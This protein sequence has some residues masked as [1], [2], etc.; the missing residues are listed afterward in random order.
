MSLTTFHLSEIL[1]DS[2]AKSS[3]N[4]DRRDSIV[5]HFAQSPRGFLL[6]LP[7]AAP[8]THPRIRPNVART[9]LAL[10]VAWSFLLP[11]FV[12]E[13]I[14][15]PTKKSLGKDD[16]D[17]ALAVLAAARNAQGFKDW[18]N[19]KELNGAETRITVGSYVAG[20]QVTREPQ[21]NNLTL[22]K[23]V[24]T[25]LY[26]LSERENGEIKRLLPVWET[27]DSRIF[28]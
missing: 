16:T 28:S 13:A 24:E 18:L 14:A 5:D 22:V 6:S 3:E 2:A 12:R 15:A 20:P 8:D 26:I 27:A 7:V 10:L 19:G 11:P 1:D 17:G 21:G 4:L 25:K 9:A 23:A